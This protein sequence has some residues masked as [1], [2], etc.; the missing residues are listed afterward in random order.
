M[1]IFMVKKKKERKNKKDL[2]LVG[3]K[4]QDSFT[5]SLIF[6]LSASLFALHF[7]TSMPFFFS[8]L[9]H[10]QRITTILNSDSKIN[11]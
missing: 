11:I 10:K 8:H 4:Y 1:N 5:F 6:P 3:C 9:L 7:L 2:N